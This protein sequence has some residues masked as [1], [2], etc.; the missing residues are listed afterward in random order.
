MPD[1]ISCERDTNG[2]DGKVF[3]ML[4]LTTTQQHIDQ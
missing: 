3:D 2:G 1:V 4:Y